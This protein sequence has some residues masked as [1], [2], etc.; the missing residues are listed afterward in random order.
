MTKE[1][2]QERKSLIDR[3]TYHKLIAAYEKQNTVSQ[4]NYYFD[5]PDFE[6][7]NAQIGLRIRHDL[8]AHSFV[9]TLKVPLTGSS[10]T[11]RQLIEITDRINAQT[12]QS[13]I[14]GTAAGF[15]GTVGAYLTQHFADIKL[16]N[17]ASATTERTI[18]LGPDDTLITV[19][20]TTYR[21]GST[22]HELEIEG[23]DSTKLKFIFD[24]LQNKFH[25]V[26]KPI[27]NK[28]DRALAHR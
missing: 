3:T 25:I 11:G 21:D 4:T 18:L 23:T 19:D 28:R 10:A 16:V 12:A 20:Q 27:Q 9:Q 7:N 15:A 26:Q 2:E 8:T 24:F 22:D 1:I 5:S 6:L 13:L 14:K 17:F